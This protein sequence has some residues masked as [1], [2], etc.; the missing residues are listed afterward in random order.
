MIILKIGGGKNIN[1]EGIITDLVNLDEQFIIV[2]GANAHRNYLAN[3]LNIQKEELI[4]IKGYSSVKS[5]P[6]IIDLMKMSYAGFV[7]KSIVELCQKHGINAIGLSGIDGGLIRG[8]RNKGIRTI[9]NGKKK[10]VRDLSGKPVSINTSLLDLLME[11]NYTPVITMPILDEFDVAVN[12]ENDDVVRLLASYYSPEKIVFLIEAIG[13][14]KDKND[15]STIYKNL[16]I[17]TLRNMVKHS[18]GRIQR[19]L[20]SIIETLQT[21]DTEIIIADGRG[22]TPISNALDNL[23]IHTRIVREQ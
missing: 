13:L 5:T 10:I 11:N 3:A 2:H 15:E 19:K 9:I 17:H 6:E 14:L 12:S 8:R 22:E 7:N 20:R 1:L 4:S 16:D 18:K 23:H 21:S